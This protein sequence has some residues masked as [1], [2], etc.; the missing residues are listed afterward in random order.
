MA[1]ESLEQES[2]AMRVSLARPVGAVQYFEFVLSNP[3]LR[4]ERTAREM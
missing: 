1:F 4:L 2:F 3:D